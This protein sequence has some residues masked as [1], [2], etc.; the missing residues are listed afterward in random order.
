MKRRRVFSGLGIAAALAAVIVHPHL[1]LAHEASPLEAFGRLP[2]LED[3]V[4]S[5]DGT[6]IAFVRTRSDSRSLVVA[7]LT[8]TEVLGGVR[9][10]DTK[11]REVKWIDDD[12]LLATISDTSLPPF[13]FTGG[14]REWYRLVNFSV[15]N[16]KLHQLDF[17]IPQK[18]T[19]NIVNGETSV[20]DVGGHSTLFVP[21][22]CVEDRTVPCL[23]SFSYPQLRARLINQVSEPSTDWLL[24]ESGLIAA[25]SVYD[26]DKKVWEIKTRRDGRWA[27]AASG[28]AAIDSPRMLGFS[29]DGSQLIVRFVEN[30]EGVWK[31]LALKDNTWGSPLGTGA[32]FAHVI[33]DRKSGRI[34]GGVR[35]IGSSQYVFFDNEL[36]A[37]W[38][39]IMRAFPDERVRLVSASDDYSRV[40]LSVFG[41]KDGYAYE[42]YDWY[43]HKATRLGEVYES[44]GAPSDVRAISYPA[45]YGLTIPGF[46]TLPRGIQ[47]KD[48]PLIVFPHGGPAAADTLDFDW[49]AQ[50]LAAQGYAVLQPNF[51]GSTLN[52]SFL[53]AG[54]GEWG[55]K[56]QTDL[57][58]GVRYL[59]HLGL[60]DPQRV[61]IVGASYGGYAALAGV[62]IQSG[63]YRCAV[64]V[65]GIS[66]L[67][68]FRKWTAQNEL[69]VSQRYWDRF[70]GTSDKNDPVIAAISPIEH[71]TSVSV[72]ILLIH[73]QDDTV[74]PY[75]QSDVMLSALQR[76]GKSVEMV[77][78]KHEDHWLSRSETRLQMLQASVAFL[79]ANNPPN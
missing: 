13:G 31:P 70:M 38:A 41:P 17:E 8:K 66:D 79:K 64:S 22:Y 28:T 46:L 65:A 21:G 1:S 14:T 42:L 48:L 76:A 7:P 37:H 49:W 53:E 6:K 11:L 51:R 58:D 40:V 54:F 29:A 2:T 39:A 36:Q 19:F 60:V 77:T 26:D 71:V 9:I 16:L 18:R 43:T 10:G 74:V 52:R 45:A 34:I 20:R 50:A 69:S 23:F 47:E 44:V 12:N 4:I 78:M 15:S 30:G 61:C 55:R 62:T 67:R 56:M 24:D 25:Q 68:R 59:V 73:G 5:P 57:S 27:S 75:E 63:V 35:E 32:E 72:P 3:V 33:E